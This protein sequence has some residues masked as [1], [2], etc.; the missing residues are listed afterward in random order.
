M[1]FLGF[2][3]IRFL[4]MLQTMP[5][6]SQLSKNKAEPIAKSVPKMGIAI[7]TCVFILLGIEEEVM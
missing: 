7:S 3:E 5:N 1:S 2:T 4:F 6:I